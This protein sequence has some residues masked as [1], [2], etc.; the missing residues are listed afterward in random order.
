MNRTFPLDINGQPFSSFS[1]ELKMWSSSNPL[2]H[3]SEHPSESVKKIFPQNAL[4][5]NYNS[6]RAWVF[7]PFLPPP[8]YVYIVPRQIPPWTIPTPGNSHSRQSQHWTVLTKDNFIFSGGGSCVKGNYHGWKLGN[9]PG[10]N[11]PG[12]QFC[13]VE[14]F[15][16]LLVMLLCACKMNINVSGCLGIGFPTLLIELKPIIIRTIMKLSGL[17]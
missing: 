14:F 1:L 3:L 16:G 17:L 8:T 2:P 15:Q 4:P 6:V 12:L 10:G 13:S 5:L 9:C 11:C 7:D